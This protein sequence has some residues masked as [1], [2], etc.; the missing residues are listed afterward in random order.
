LLLKEEEGLAEKRYRGKENLFRAGPEIVH[1][2]PGAVILNENGV[3]ARERRNP[4]RDLFSDGRA[5][6]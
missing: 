1:N 5:L 4:G 2:W 6:D 3:E